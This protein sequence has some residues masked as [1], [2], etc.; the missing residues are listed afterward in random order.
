MKIVSTEQINQCQL[1]NNS[2]YRTKAG[3]MFE[4]EI[5]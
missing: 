5:K 2:V 3:I 4:N 1:T